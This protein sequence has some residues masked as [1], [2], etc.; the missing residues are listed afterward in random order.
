[1]NQDLDQL[2]QTYSRKVYLYLLSLSHDT[3]LSGDLMQDTFLKAAR[4]IDTFQ[5]NSPLSFW[6]A[7]S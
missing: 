7:L 6:L 5:Q 1:M 2:Y 4:K 3:A